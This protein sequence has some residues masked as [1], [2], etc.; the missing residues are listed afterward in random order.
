[1]GDFFKF[2]ISV[3]FVAG[4]SPGPLTTVIYSLLT[5]PLWFYLLWYI[6]IRRYYYSKRPREV[7]LTKRTEDPDVAAERQRA[8][9]MDGSGALVHMAHL[10]KEFPA[11]KKKGKKQPNKVAVVDLSLAID[12]AGCFALLGP[13]GA[14]KTTTL[15]MLT[16]D[17]RPTAGEASVGGYSVRT[18]IMQIFKRLGYC[19]QFGGLFTRGVTL[20]QHLQ[21]FARLKGVPEKMLEAHCKRTLAEFGLE[22]HAHKWVGKLSGGTRRK[23]VAAIALA[24]E[25][26]VC[27]LDEPTTGVDVGTRQFL[28][29]RI[30]AK[31][32]RGC[33][34]ILTTHYMEEADALAQRVGIM[35]NGELKVLGSPQHLKSVHGGGYRIEIKGPEA[36]AAQAKSL[37]EGLFADTTQLE[38]HG[39]FQVFEV[40]K[41]SRGSDGLFQLSPVFSKLDEAKASMGIENYTLSQTTLEQVF[42][43]IASEQ[44]EEEPK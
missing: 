43:N 23:L 31:G 21:F 22:A 10:R 13:N 15:S 5:A 25:P 42:L 37:V 9:A 33:A 26:Q 4:S 44:Q 8:E 20:K 24:C 7:V 3:P 14:G 18:D 38:S 32:A 11:P 12:G 16:G 19:P 41:G 6:D 40:G 17:L 28:W 27:F 30:N 29:D 35:V 36:T 34:L 39:G 2:T 1:V